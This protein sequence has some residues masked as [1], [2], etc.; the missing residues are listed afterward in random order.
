MLNADLRFCFRTRGIVDGIAVDGVVKSCQKR[1]EFDLDLT[2]KS[3]SLSTL[4]ILIPGL[5]SNRTSSSE[6]LKSRSG[7]NLVKT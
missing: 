6:K 5:L 1:L 7:K 4:S 2:D 3:T